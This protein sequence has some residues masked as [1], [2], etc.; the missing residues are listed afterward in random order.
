MISCQL[1]LSAFYSVRSVCSQQT[2]HQASTTVKWI[3][4]MVSRT[5]QVLV[6]SQIS[7]QS[8]HS[9]IT[10]CQRHN[11]RNGE[12]LLFVHGE[13]HTSNVVVQRQDG[14]PLLLLALQ[15]S[16]L[17]GNCLKTWFD[18]CDRFP[19]TTCFTLNEKK[20][21]FLLKNGVWWT[22]GVTRYI[23]LCWTMQNGK[24]KIQNPK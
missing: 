10:S 23:F 21:S 13:N 14:V 19:G 6:I 4:E 17:L 15:L 9:R 16:S 8:L 11:P 18:A 2:W 5:L 20:P 3:L 24:L 12:V 22:T 1:S 7:I